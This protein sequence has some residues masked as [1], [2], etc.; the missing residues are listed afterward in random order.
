MKFFSSS[1]PLLSNCF[2]FG[3]KVKRAIEEGV[4]SKLFFGGRIRGKK[5]AVPKDATRQQ[6]YSP[7]TIKNYL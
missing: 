7:P 4:G 5:K 1:S 6:N 2:I 3:F